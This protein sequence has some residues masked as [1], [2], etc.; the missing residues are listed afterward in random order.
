VQ[1]A[2]YVANAGSS[3]TVR[4]Q[5]P[6]IHRGRRLAGPCENFRLWIGKI[7]FVQ[8]KPDQAIVIEVEKRDP[9]ENSTCATE[10]KDTFRVMLE[11]A[12][13]RRIRNSDP[14]H[15]L[16]RQ[17]DHDWQFRWHDWPCVDCS[18]LTQAIEVVAG[19]KNL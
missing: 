9:A 8:E 10:G 15:R 4:R 2:A 17:R 19:P 14:G 11:N 16:P 13:N 6:H 12:L 5:R 18:V 1:I 3:A 7:D